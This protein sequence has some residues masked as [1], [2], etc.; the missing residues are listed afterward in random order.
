MFNRKSMLSFV[1]L[2]TAVAG[3]Q[4]GTLT[5]ENHPKLS[6]QK[7]TG[8]GS[9]AVCTAQPGS[10]VLD[11]N[12]RWTHTTSGSTNCYD[13]ST[14]NTS[15]CPNGVTCAQNCAIDGADY[16]GTYGITT[17]G[18]ALTL[19]YVTKGPYSTNVGSR[20]YLMDNSDSK[21]ELFKPNNKEFTFDVDVSNLPCGL[22]GALY[23][24]EMAADGGLSKYPGNKAGAKYGTG[25]CDAQCPHDIK[26]INGEVRKQNIPQ[27]HDI[28]NPNVLTCASSRLTLKDGTH[29]PLTPTPVTDDMVLAAL[30]WIS[31]KPTPSP[32]HTLLTHVPFRDNIDA[33]VQLSAVM[34]PT[35]T[36]PFATRMVVTS[37][38]TVWVTRASMVLARLSTLSKR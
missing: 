7:C 12:W 23:F 5:P 34:V 26:F 1:L 31:G 13:G 33:T 16:S 9:S 18:N 17:S 24:S 3:Q 10:V 27:S 8:T 29:L 2:A 22:N 4:V 25:Y 19:R 11:S 14:W 36:H 21:Y 37:T 28:G 15:L 20:V 32:L 35:D 6:W 30:R 38:P